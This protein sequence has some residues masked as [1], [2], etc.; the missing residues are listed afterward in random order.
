MSPIYQSI[1]DNKYTKIRDDGL[2]WSLLVGFLMIL[3]RSIRLT[4]KIKSYGSTMRTTVTC[5]ITS[6]TLA[7]SV[8]AR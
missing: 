7:K 4:G 2:N 8:M 1:R 3:K 6:T 5:A